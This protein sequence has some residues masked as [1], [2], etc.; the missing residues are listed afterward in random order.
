VAE[1]SAAA[2]SNLPTVPAPTRPTARTD[3]LP[4]AP[5]RDAPSIPGYEI[6]GELGYGGMG[7]VYRARQV[8]L[9]RV[10]ALKMIRAGDA[11]GEADLARFR[12]EAEAVARLRHPNIVQIYEIGEHGGRPYF[13]LEFVEGGSL[14]RR[15]AGA[16]LPPREAAALAETLARAVD[17]AHRAGVV[18]R[19]LKPANVLLA[20]GPD[21]APDLGRP[22]V[23]DF[24]LA[25]RLD[26][27]SGR[28]H[29]GALVGTPS[30]M[31]P[32][33]AA[34]HGKEAG[35]AADIYA[36]GA[37]LYETLIGR[38][39]FKTADVWET[40]LQVARDDPVPP[41]DLQPGLPR[42]LE[43]VCLKCLEKE[44]RRRYAS[45]EAL[46]DDL[47]RFLGDEPVR[48]RPAG[49]LYRA[50]KFTQRNKAL[51]G[52]AAAALFALTLGLAGTALGLAQARAA[53]REARRLLAASYAQTAELAARRG[54]WRDAL[55]NYD[56]ALEA[57]HPDSASLRLA[58]A[59]AWLAL[60][61][62][63]KALVE[64]DELA[65]RPD[66][67][68][69]AGPV[70][71]WRADLRL[72]RAPAAEADQYLSEFERALKS[73]LPPAEEAYARGMLARTLPEAVERLRE[74]VGHDPFHQRARALLAATYLVLARYSE[75][76]QQVAVAE[77]LFPDDPTFPVLHAQALT[78][79]G[80]PDEARALLD[81]DRD[82]LGPKR[83]AAARGALEVFREVQ[84]IARD[85]VRALDD[86]NPWPVLPRAAA[87]ATKI[88]G[89]VDGVSLP[90]H[91]VL[92]RA[93]KGG[94]ALSTL[95]GLAFG[96][97]WTS[98][99]PGEVARVWP[100]GLSHLAHGLT[101]FSEGKYAESE[102]AFLR[103]AQ[104]PSIADVRSPALYGAVGAQA[105]LAVET[106]P[107]ADPGTRGRCVQSLR[108]LLALGDLPPV[109]ARIVTMIA[110][111]FEEWE[112]ARRV[113]VA[114][115]RQAPEDLEARQ[116]RAQLEFRTESYDQALRAANEVLRKDPKNA[117]A[118]E[119]RD[120]SARRLRE[121]VKALGPPG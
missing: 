24:G 17:A 112:L 77:A 18:H 66:L 7:V 104:T 83:H 38:P 95:S 14:S 50:R 103:A 93:F 37:V 105:L 35:P 15:L 32:E 45:A 5:V 69:L 8:S 21:G 9:G 85:T 47:R 13:S 6:L 51:V 121:Q 117:K 79:E 101:L 60:D 106:G 19:D 84:G 82:R 39:P 97:G 56:R 57:G 92:T 68:D 43:A 27:P 55:A 2:A 109:R 31:A 58:K 10:V 30:Y 4:T 33:Q 110:M 87:L 49:A 46:A 12:A 118:R 67:G 80:R 114:W 73:G 115:Q 20:A 70:A 74:A 91:P 116:W 111:R 89:I 53:E 65:G 54:A 107:K 22:K 59:K 23:A 94:G 102:A 86:Q 81:R 3:T 99:W 44:P 75:C 36:L 113:I 96:G 108:A 28:T 63:D 76:R 34:G 78:L 11:A 26:D 119:I 41:R 62:G 61:E 42:D 120:E 40:M 90:L 48:A 88:N 25:K 64:L 100:E 52:G 71:L 98:A 72:A 16:P 29:E 1:A